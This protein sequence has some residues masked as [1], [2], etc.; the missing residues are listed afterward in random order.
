MKKL[1]IGIALGIAAAVLL[2]SCGSASAKAKGGKIEVFS[3]K[4]ESIAT[5]QGLIDEFRKVHPEIEVTLT[6]PPEAETVLKTRLAKNDLPDVFSVGGN[7]TFGDLARAGAFA[8]LASTDAAKAVHPAYL[9]MLTRLVGN[10]DGAVYG[11]PYATNANGVIYNKAKF[12]KLGLAPPKTWSELIALLKKAKAAGETPI[13]FT[14]QD[15]WT[16]LIPWNAL[17]SN[18]VASDF[19]KR[20]TAKETTFA[21]E[22]AEVADKIATLVTYGH[23]DNFGIGYGDGNSAFA[24][25]K[26]VLLLQ[27]NW[28]V[29][30]LL[31]ANPE[32]KLGVFPM[33]VSDDVS[34]NK[35]V[36]GVDVL[37]AVSAKTK[38]AA[39]AQAFVDFMVGK[40]IAGRYIAEQAAF[41]AVVGVIQEN[42]VMEGFKPSFEAGALSSFAD[43]YYPAGFPVAAAV[44]AYLQDGNKKAFL[45]KLDE[46][47]N[48]FTTQ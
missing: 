5:L 26:G 40:E 34:K 27:G 43:H 17:S 30:E 2:A 47:W 4:S 1:R 14:L 44:Q 31:K 48:K 11:I 37:L 9:E 45:D 21:K 22:Y 33:P 12:E 46:E 23:S 3:N 20:R 13:L 38:N 19:P 10:A 18:L 35:L 28:A 32:V 42:P 15:A 36:S 6:A 7:A 8:N 24:N 29:P 39:A 41:S 16:G 25:G